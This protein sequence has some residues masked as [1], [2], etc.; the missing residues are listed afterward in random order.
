[1]LKK[2]KTLIIDEAGVNHNGKITYAKKLIDGA[3]SAGADYVKFQPMIL[4]YLC[5]KQN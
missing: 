2:T 1:M 5:Q 3:A 4:I